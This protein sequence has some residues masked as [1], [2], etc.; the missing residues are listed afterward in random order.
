MPE[1]FDLEASDIRLLTEIGFLGAGYG[2]TSPAERLFQ[3]LRTLRP[4]RGFPYIG[5]GLCLLSKG[6]AE[7][8]AK[9]LEQSL[10]VAGEDSDMVKAFQGYALLLAKRSH[11]G[12]AILE[13]VTETGGDPQAV[14]LAKSVL[15]SI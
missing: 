6:D 2:L 15:E 9:L 13:Q 4:E 8:A 10:P 1:S 7:G 5:L 3:G 14:K 11:H 12:R